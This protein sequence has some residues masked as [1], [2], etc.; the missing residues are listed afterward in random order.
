[1]D[2]IADLEKATDT[3]LAVYGTLRPGQIKCKC[4]KQNR[5]AAEKNADHLIS[6]G[7]PHR[8]NE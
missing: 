3:R 4:G 7:I 1:M 6:I 5:Y 2:E 8:F